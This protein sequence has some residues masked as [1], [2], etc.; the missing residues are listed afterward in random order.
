MWWATSTI[1]VVAT[2]LTLAS[3]LH[4][5]TKRRV[6]LRERRVLGCPEKQPLGADPTSKR[7]DLCT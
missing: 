5:R 6:A 2:T 4:R 3:T 1:G 7:P